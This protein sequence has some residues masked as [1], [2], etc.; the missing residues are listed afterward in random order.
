MKSNVGTRH[1]LT[2]DLAH[3][4]ASASPERILAVF[5]FHGLEQVTVLYGTT[6]RDAFLQRAESR[7]AVAISGF[8]R[9]YKPRRD[10]FCVILDG[11]LEQAIVV[12]DAATTALNDVGSEQRIHAETGVAILPDEA[13]DPITALERADRRVVPDAYQSG[14]ERRRRRRGDPGE[15]E[16]ESPHTAGSS[17]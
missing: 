6:G 4:L 1:E 7:L 15:R 9:C 13:K 17:R 16:A 5:K 10:E 8:G 3:A 12:L 11:P 2:V 14:R